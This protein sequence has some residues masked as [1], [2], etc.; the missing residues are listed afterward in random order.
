MFIDLIIIAAYFNYSP[1]LAS[2]PLIGLRQLV[3][4]LKLHIFQSAVNYYII[5]E[6]NWLCNYLPTIMKKN[7]TPTQIWSI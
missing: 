7:A 2:G 4:D 3:L 1:C 6:F 5:I